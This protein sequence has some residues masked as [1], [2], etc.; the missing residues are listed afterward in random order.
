[1]PELKQSIRA[2]LAYTIWAD[3]QVLEALAAVQPEHL[4]RDTG[5]SFGSI[6]G[7]MAHILG[8]EQV[9]LSRLVGAPLD[10]LPSEQDYA[11]LPTLA[12]GFFD[13]WPQLEVFLAS[14]A[15]E[16]VRAEL[17][18]T[19]YRGETHS[20]PMHVVLLH[21]AN[22]STYHRGQVVALLRQLGYEP[23]STDLIYWKGSA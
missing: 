5:T 3:R 14:L 11:D 22:H 4:T 9:W 12:A 2:L 19:N 15:D 13:Y 10:H 8:A 16:Q 1:M 6:L 23:P 20:A 21:F 18:W 17:T 7:T